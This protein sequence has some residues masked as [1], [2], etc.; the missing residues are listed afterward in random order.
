M[1]DKP[2][3]PEAF[4]ET[5][6]KI[7]I[8]APRGHMETSCYFQPLPWFSFKGSLLPI[9]F[10]CNELS[11]LDSTCQC[12]YL[13]EDLILIVLIKVEMHFFLLISLD[14]IVKVT[15]DISERIS[16]GTTCM[17]S[18]TS[19]QTIYSGKKGAVHVGQKC[20]YE[21]GRHI[22][23]PSWEED[24]GE[25]HALCQPYALSHQL[26]HCLAASLLMA[27]WERQWFGGCH[28]VR[29]CFYH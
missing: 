1:K 21:C 17:T 2:Q 29:L 8:T 9:R 20:G 27:W 23:L 5:L 15:A 3:T 12:R 25:C 10:I 16:L 22:A 28:S 19:S 7:K 18:D 26:R 6:G 14:S 11:G 13:N 4:K 24:S